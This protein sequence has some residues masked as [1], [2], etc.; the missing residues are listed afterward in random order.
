[1]SRFYTAEIFVR[2]S[3]QREDGETVS[4]DYPMDPDA[5]WETVFLD[6]HATADGPKSPYELRREHGDVGAR[7]WSDAVRLRA[8]EDELFKKAGLA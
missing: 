8:C 3:V 4:V 2:L 7:R 5:N 1:M 6:A